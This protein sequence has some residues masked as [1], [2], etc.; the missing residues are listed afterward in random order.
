MLNL[1]SHELG[2]TQL[3]ELNPF[4]LVPLTTEVGHCR[5]LVLNTPVLPECHDRTSNL[6][7]DVVAGLFLS[8]SEVFDRCF[9]VDAD[10]RRYKNAALLNSLGSVGSAHH[11]LQCARFEVGPL[12]EDD[13]VGFTC[14][15]DVETSG[16]LLFH[17]E[18]AFVD[19]F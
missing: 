19:A 9:W 8:L 3:A 14:E 4:Q 15:P 10:S 11:L 12:V 2:E 5:S 6:C 13:D 18:H 17:D 1:S 7:T 16:K